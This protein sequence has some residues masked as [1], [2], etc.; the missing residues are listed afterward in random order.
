MAMGEGGGTSG[1]Q[2]SQ[3]GGSGESGEVLWRYEIYTDVN[4]NI[5]SSQ[6]GYN[7]GNREDARDAGKAFMVANLPDA[8]Y[9]LLVRSNNSGFPPSKYGPTIV[10][11]TPIEPGPQPNQPTENPDYLF[12]GAINPGDYGDYT[13][14]GKVHWYGFQKLY[15]EAD[16]E[17]RQLHTITTIRPTYES[18]RDQY[19]ATVING[20]YDETAGGA[21]VNVYAKTTSGGGS[22]GLMFAAIAIMIT[23]GCLLG[24]VYLRAKPVVEKVI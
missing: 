8:T 15:N 4:Y 14:D 20:Y 1:G 5:L 3:S 11:N 21:W 16:P 10:Q 12:G 13:K 24:Y 9:Y 2:G 19:K 17:P 22:G 7:Y 18:L 23:A 6:S